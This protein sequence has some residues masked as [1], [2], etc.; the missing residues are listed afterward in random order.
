MHIYRQKVVFISTIQ[1]WSESVDKA[2]HKEA[3][4]EIEQLNGSPINRIDVPSE[5]DLSVLFNVSC[6]PIRRPPSEMKGK[7]LGK[8]SKRILSVGEKEQKKIAHS[9]SAFNS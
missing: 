5:M 9:F 7:H 3:E 6:L 4:E 8:I 1:D 2:W